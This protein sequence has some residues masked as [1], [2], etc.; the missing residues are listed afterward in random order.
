MK[1]SYQYGER[2]TPDAFR[3][4]PSRFRGAPF[5]AWNGKLDKELLK[6]QMDVF[7]EM[8]F[9]GF[10]IHSRIGLSTEYLG[11]EFMECVKFCHEYGNRKGLTTYLYDEDKWPSG[12][13]GGRVTKKEEYRARYLLFSP[14]FHKDG[15]Y[16]RNLPPSCRLTE[17]GDLK[18]LACYKVS[19]EDGKLAGYERIVSRDQAGIRIQ[20]PDSTDSK[21]ESAGHWYVY[22]V[23]GDKLPWFNNEAYGDTLNPEAVKYFAQV[24]YEPYY[25]ALGEEFSVT[26]PSIFTDEPQFA[27]LQNMAD[28]G[29]PQEAGIPYT[30]C[31]EA[32]FR[33][34]F[35]LELLDILPEIFWEKADGTPASNRYRYMNAVAD[36]F[37][38]SYAGTLSQWCEEHHIMLT[39]HLME[40]GSL[41]KQARSVGDAMRSYRYF[42]MPGIDMLADLREY[43]TAKQAQSVA[44]Q[45]GKPGLSSELY[46]VTNWDFDF[47]GHKLQGDWQ[48]ALGVTTRVHHLSW[49]YM[50][51]ES[52][53]DYP[54]PIDAHSPWY[55][56]YAL[57]EDYFGRIGMVMT[58]GRAVADICVIHPIESMFLN[59]G[60]DS[61]T[62]VKRCRLEEEFQ[63]V[64]EWL[65]FGLLDFDFVSEA[66]LPLLPVKAED[67]RLEIGEMKYTTVIVPALTTIRRTTL[68]ILEMFRSAGGRILVMG[69]LPECMDGGPD[70]SL[71]VLMKGYDRIGMDKHALWDYLEPS[72]RVDIT[73]TSGIRKNDLI[74]QLRQEEDH[75][76]LFLAHGRTE[77]ISTFSVAPP[78][79][80][81]QRIVI[82]LKGNFNIMVYDAM[83]GSTSEPEYEADG[84]STKV[85]M[86][87]WEQDSILLKLTPSD[88]PISPRKSSR[89]ER[90]ALQ[91]RL[92]SET[93]YTLEEP[94]VLL[95]DMAEYSLDGGEWHSKEEILRIDDIAREA[96]GYRKRTDSFPQPW[97]NKGNDR[98]E[99]TVM[100][101]FRTESRGEGMDAELAFE[102]T[103]EWEL[104]F[105]GEMVPAGLNETFLDP[106]IHRIKLGKIKRGE[107][108]L[109]CQI[110]FGEMTGLEW[111]YL[112]GDFAVRLTGSIPVLEE[113]PGKVGFGNYTT[114][115]FPFYGGNF[116]YELTVDTPA[117]ETELE[118]GEYTA[119]L[120]EACADGGSPVPMFAAPYRIPLGYLQAG[121]HH[122]KIRSF[123]SRINMFGQLHNANKYEKYFGPK[124]WRTQGADWCYEYRLHPCGIRKAPVL[125]I[126]TE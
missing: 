112:L 3:N 77:E 65:L 80:D 125:I 108:I 120:I 87:C 11:K 29:V 15:H 61:D 111:F 5:W 114:Q 9:G 86:D 85:Y 28:G 19:L 33:E 44:R 64:T 97:L 71:T 94:N 121:K 58:R 32:V 54:A 78:K 98:K 17:D 24:G 79:A 14:A 46:G 22:R 7:K 4:P 93:G 6:E 100:L 101:R 35:G 13:G 72:R 96:F 69:K 59:L 115:G 16:S 57:M 106:S 30:E 36:L 45:M 27:K 116:C 23:I 104:H 25:E 10:H 60:P 62:Y 126:L 18:L 34:K 88:S 124:T 51:G 1:K 118:I 82:S 55:K 66:L 75:Q 109:L 8:G 63:S 90:K 110:P 56:R 107:N 49:M 31:L 43:T 76:W 26:I 103:E 91:I 53:R 41:E 52:K 50:G 47:R 89:Q 20:D 99:H 119:P 113:L 102:G 83:S 95:W 12:Y 67:G 81:R 92:P 21:Y 48:A 74:C 84:S 2:F 38:Q 37:A 68:D 40:E 117:G 122:I 73:D 39:G 42:Q 70:S 105:N 123:G